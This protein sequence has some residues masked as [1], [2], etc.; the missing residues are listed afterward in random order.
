LRKVNKGFTLIELLVVIAI[1]A[2]LAAIL[3][4]VLTGA[5]ENA[6]TTTCMNNLKTLANGCAMYGA[7]NSGKYPSAFVLW[8]APDWCGCICTGN[9]E[10]N[11]RKGSLWKYIRN[12]SVFRCPSE[13][14]ISPARISPANPDYAISYSMNWTVGATETSGQCG[15]KGRVTVDSVPRPSKVLLFIHESDKANGIDDGCF[16]WLAHTDYNES[17]NQPSNRHNGGTVAC[18]VDGHAR[19]MNYKQFLSERDSGVWDACP[20]V[21]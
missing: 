21:H 2:I 1:I 19:A 8:K 3:F 16:Y 9:P 18:Y 7:D 4:P 15:G 5:K 10:V 20:S 11:V 6:R 14:K 13:K 12:E 17:A